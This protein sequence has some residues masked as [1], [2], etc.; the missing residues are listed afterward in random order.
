M[1]TPARTAVTDL[2]RRTMLATGALALA[3]AAAQSVPAHAEVAPKAMFPV[4]AVT[5]PIVGATEVFQVRR[6]YCIGRNYA[7]HAIERGSDPTRE[8]PFFFQK[9]T[10]AIQNVAI[11]TVA[12]H[13]YPS[14]T[15][16]Y[17]H[18]VELVAALKSGGTN[19]PADKALEHVYGYAL[20]LDMTRRDLQNGMAAE[21]KPWEIGK[22]FDHA[23]VLGPIHPADKTGH[24]TQG[25]ISL[26]VNGTVRQSSDLKNMIWSV[27]E[28]IAKLSEAFELKAGDIIYSGTP[29]NVGPVVKGDV[30]L[31]KLEGLPDMS[32]KIV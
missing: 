25:A 15:K 19:I 26:A 29:E 7:A 27:A 24:F 21:K 32:I 9:P 12:D 4:A 14:L 1:K 16:N 3:G 11:G 5:I 31:C 20:G 22:S 30:L 2:D 10:D 17:H 28:Q 18:E 13:P 6:I 8:P 23:A